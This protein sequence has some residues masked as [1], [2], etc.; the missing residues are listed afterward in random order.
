MFSSGSTGGGIFGTKIALGNNND[1]RKL[2][3]NQLAQ[4]NITPVK[5][6][7]TSDLKQDLM[8]TNSLDANNNALFSSNPIVPKSQFNNNSNNQNIFGQPQ[9]QN[10]NQNNNNN[11]PS[12][13]N[14]FSFGLNQT[15]TPNNPPQSSSSFLAQNKTQNTEKIES[16][17]SRME[18]M[19]KSIKQSDSNLFLGHQS[20]SQKQA[21]DYFTQRANDDDDDV[22][23]DSDTESD[24]DS[25]SD[26]LYGSQNY[27]SHYNF[28]TYDDYNSFG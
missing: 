13:F 24:S 23:T 11:A 1:P 26:G 25:D 9:N 14:S 19:E 12:N 21:Y 4:D 15:S 17:M 6:E 18:L 3:E 10:Q 16:K 2:F 28:D 7:D 20:L 5:R 27:Y 22:S 8:Q